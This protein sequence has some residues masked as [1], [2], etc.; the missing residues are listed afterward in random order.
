L[1][2]PILALVAFVS[3]ARAEIWSYS[4]TDMGVDYTLTFESLSGNVGTY[5][6]TLDTNGYT[7]PS[8]AYLDAVAIMAWEGQPTSVQ[9]ISFEQGGTSGD[10]NDWSSFGGNVASG[11]CRAKRAG[12]GCVEADTKGVFD[13]S[14]GTTYSF[15]FEV[16]ADSFLMD[17]VGAHIGAAYANQS[18]NGSGYGITHLEVTS[19]A[20]VPEPEIYAMMLVGLGLL[21]LFV[22]ARRRMPHYASV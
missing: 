14:S 8:G 18:G 22:G 10:T 5:E 21:I 6:L 15:T 12:F 7:G 20:M 9:L 17:P 4:I 11:G 13:V 2:A 3:P 16:T 19:V 1:I